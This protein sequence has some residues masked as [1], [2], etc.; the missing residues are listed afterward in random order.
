MI[1]L[2]TIHAHSIDYEEVAKKMNT[3][4]ETGLTENEAQ[5]R[6]EEYGRNELIKEK[7]KTA[8]QIFISQFK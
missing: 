2:K 7:R 6:L 3:S 5:K 1:D 4:V 8:L